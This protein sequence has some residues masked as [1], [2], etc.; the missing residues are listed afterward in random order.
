MEDTKLD[1][2]YVD[3]RLVELYDSA[4]PLGSD[5]EFYLQ[6]AAEL[7]AQT[8]VDLGCSTGLLTRKLARDNRNVIGIDPAPA[9]L[10]VARRN[11]K[12]QHIQWVEGDRKALGTP[13]ADLL[14]MTGN[15]AQVFLDDAEWTATL[16]AIRTALRPNGYLIFES[17]NP[18]ARSW[19][20]WNREETHTITSTP[21]G[22]IEEWL[23]VIDDSNGRVHFKG[24]N[25][26]KDTGEVLVVDSELRFRCKDELIDSLK[27]AG[28]T[29]ENIYGDWGRGPFT[30][31]SPIIVLI[32]RLA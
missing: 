9:M 27:K 4:N 12:A 29:V 16:D 18:D 32:A 7:K 8:I 30:S 17:R 22:Q 20:H 31:A 6:M 24:Y 26:F 28:F 1:L 2:H 15:V 21:F 10:A 13:D 23:E 3:P 5:T 14:I 11:D 25:I 19:E